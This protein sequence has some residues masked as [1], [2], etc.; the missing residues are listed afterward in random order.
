MNWWLKMTNNIFEQAKVLLEI[1]AEMQAKYH[2]RPYGEAQHRVFQPPT[3]MIDKPAVYRYHL[4]ELFER[5]RDDYSTTYGTKAEALIV[6]M[7]TS[8]SMPLNRNGDALYCRLFQE[9][10]DKLPPGY[11]KAPPMVEMYEGAAQ[12]LLIKIQ[13]MNRKEDRKWVTT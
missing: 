4:I 11:N 1:Y 3:T 12:E 5:V 13:K 2:I 7:A 9:C 6:L 8:L 10:F